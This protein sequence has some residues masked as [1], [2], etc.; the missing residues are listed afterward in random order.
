MKHK[1]VVAGA[2][3][4]G[5]RL[6]KLLGDLGAEPLIVSWDCGGL[7][8]QYTDEG[9][10]FDYGGHVYTPV[11]PDV[12]NLM[13]KSGAVEHDRNAVYLAKNG[14][15]YPYPVQDH[16]NVKTHNFHKVPEAVNMQELGRYAF[17]GHFYDWFFGPF[18][19]RVWTVDPIEMDVDWIKNRVKL[20][21]PHSGEG[22]K[23]GPN[24]TFLYAQGTSITLNLIRDVNK[25]GGSIIHG[26]VDGVDLE[27]KRLLVSNVKNTRHIE[28]ET[29]FW[30]LPISKLSPLVGISSS[31]F[32]MNHVL[33]VGIG[34]RDIL[35]YDFHWAYF[36][37][38]LSPH[39]VTLLSRYHPRNSPNGKDSLLIE[40]PHR[41]PDYPLP[42]L[43]APSLQMRTD[44][45][46]NEAVHRN[47]GAKVLENANLDI[48]PQLI[49]VVS[50]GNAPGYP[51]PTKGIRGIVAE[52]KKRLIP[53]SIY[54]AGRWGSW[55]YFNIDHCFKD[56]QAAIGW[57]V[58]A[59]ED[60]YD[61]YLYSRFYYG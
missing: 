23:W 29:L 46:T 21:A 4:T 13:E 44:Y 22:K 6:G 61:E 19:R 2:G 52:T 39:R 17:G 3:I 33:S 43:F 53:H 30:T 51:I 14:I 48:K 15:V 41:W 10:H 58:T 8:E 59:L 9:F 27:R 34:F 50:V 18:N 7:I 25:S 49:E 26:K 45:T 20:P 38:K 42:R 57:S 5:L 60:E 24:A 31:A 12:R 32:L 37:V 47:V 36:D 1:V 54:T 40:Y 55:G 16:V 56:A 35:P 11:D 28:Y